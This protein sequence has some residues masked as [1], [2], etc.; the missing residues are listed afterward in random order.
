MTHLMSDDMM[1][2]FEGRLKT[3]D[4]VVKLG[5]GLLAGAFALG[6]WAATLEW[7]AQKVEDVIH[8]HSSD[9]SSMVLWKAETNG[10]RYSSGDAARDRATT[11]EQ[12]TLQDKRLTRVEDSVQSINKALDRIETKLGTK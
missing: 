1:E 7:R 3:L 9:I 10:S 8:H 5:C 11:Q 6:V 4:I 12:M 2:R